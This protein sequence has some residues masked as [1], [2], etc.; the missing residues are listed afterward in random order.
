MRNH[1]GSIG[2]SSPPSDVKYSAKG[3]DANFRT[4]RGI[5]NVAGA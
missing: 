1:G 2:G 5:Q 4:S 3:S